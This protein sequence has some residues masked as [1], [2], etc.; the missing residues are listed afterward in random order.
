MMY[1]SKCNLQLKNK[2]QVVN[3][4]LADFFSILNE[5]NVYFPK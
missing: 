3:I 1:K 2:P 4:F 5:K